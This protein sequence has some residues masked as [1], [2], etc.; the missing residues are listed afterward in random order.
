MSEVNKIYLLRGNDTPLSVCLRKR[1]GDGDPVPYDLSAAERIRLALVGHGAHVF[2]SGVTVSGEDNNIVSGVIP[3][4][5]LLK[6]DYDL[7]VT[8][9]SGGRDKRFAV[10]DMF[11]AVDF[12]AED[13]DGET[14]GE[15]AGIWVN[16]TVQPEVIEIAG[17]T[18]P[19]GYT[20]VL[21]ADEDGTIYADGV[22][23]TEVVKDVTE[24]VESAERSRVTAESQRVAAE[25]ERVRAE[26]G[27]AAAETARESASATA[28]QNAE[29]ATADANTA[30]E[31]AE[32]A[33]ATIDEKIAE[34]A[35]QSEVSQLG[36]K[37][38]HKLAVTSRKN[39]TENVF[40]R[41]T[42]MVLEDNW[43]LTDYIPITPGLHTV[44][45]NFGFGLYSESGG[46][47][48]SFYRTDGTTGNVYVT[49][50]NCSNY[51]DTRTITFNATT[52]NATRMR[53]SFYK[54]MENGDLNLTPIIIDGV[55]YNIHDD[56]P[57]VMD[58]EEKKWKPLIL[59]PLVNSDTSSGQISHS[60]VYDPI[61]VTMLNALALPKERM[62]VRY[63]QPKVPYRINLFF[64]YGNSNGT[65]STTTGS[66]MDDG[67][68]W[69]MP[70]TAKAFRVVFR[71]K[72][73]T[74][75]GGSYDLPISAEEFQRWVESGELGIEYYDET[76]E[77][78]VER[79]S[80]KTVMIEALRRNLDLSALQNSG[81]DKFPIFAH[82]SDLHGD[83][84]RFE[85]MMVF[86]ELVGGID[87][88][89]NSGD[90][91]LNYH[92]DGTGY[93]DLISG[94][95]STP[96]LMCIGNH[97]SS[98]T[99]QSSLF[100]DNMAALV[101]QQGYLKDAD[102]PADHC[103]Y[104]MDFAEKS[105]RV[106]VLNYYEDGVYLGRLGQAQ[107]TW[108]TDTLLS[109]PAGYGVVI[110]LHSPED[111][112]VASSPLDKFMQPS[113][114]YGDT[115]QPGGFYVG[116][117]PIMRIVDAF[118]ARTSISETYNDHSASYNGS[119]D[120][121]T[122]A[123]TINADFSNIPSST[124]FIA[125]VTGHRHEDNVGYYSHATQKQ[126]CLG[127]VCGISLFGDSSNPAWA[128][129]CDL[130]RGGSG[131]S[132]D[133]FN[134]YSVDRA[135]GNVRIVRVGANVTIKFE[136]RDLMIIPYKD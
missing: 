63:R 99:G 32:E 119:G 56:I 20:P 4:R 78:V 51:R 81:M 96:M 112:V 26:Q 133:A 22:L 7:E 108:F 107:I 31:H 38:A 90:A 102:T 113:P 94:K 95:H 17:P 9:R 46:P 48:I 2:A 115:Y 82:I 104:Y 132:Q 19:R 110:M 87:A 21:T 98:P 33:A 127:I 29:T 92:R 40:L 67:M 117:R 121:T 106:I 126:L 73:A 54:T 52:I 105:I 3:G 131:V 122:E 101:T 5:A 85:N 62:R 24:A 130:P 75:A 34:K 11:V 43:C 27:R 55:P 128:N 66:V 61:R 45:W 47:T 91:T 30:A 37:M 97:E 72:Y 6:G 49:Y 114:K 111:E 18:G 71:A 103:Y 83:A 70:S 125:Y 76:E 80:E 86:S 60:T 59:G 8:F 109:T 77:G 65:I 120:M 88:A 116:N 44:V 15:G 89:L 1:E 93:I 79:N 13:A 100:A 57:G 25:S 10:E 39:Y 16:V 42:S 36:L 118:I 135:N 84:A 23:L 134:V 124:E 129:Q 50:F 58:E 14:E 123:V 68:E 53:V 69:V 12:L 74:S 41:E 136:R 64:W 35:D 28:V